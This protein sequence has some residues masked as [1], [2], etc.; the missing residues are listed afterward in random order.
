MRALRVA[1]RIYLVVTLCLTAGLLASGTLA[2]EARRERAA[3]QDV[4]HHDLEARRLATMTAVRFKRQV[5]EWKDILLR[6]YEPHALVK[7]TDAFERESRAVR[8]TIDT[9]RGTTADPAAL[10]LA[11]R[12]INAHRT[13]G[14]RYAA[15]LAVFRRADG[16]DPVTTDRMVQGQDRGATAVLDTLG[17]VLTARAAGRVSV[18]QS[19][20]AREQGEILAAVVVLLGLVAAVSASTVRSITRPL[21]VLTAAADALSRG[22]IRPM[23]D[24]GTAARRDELG[25]LARAVQGSG[26]YLRAAAGT[27]ERLACGELSMLAA[28]TSSEDV[29]AQAFVVL[30]NA[31]GG[32]TSEIS[33]VAEAA[34]EGRL[35]VR[36]DA[37]RFDGAFGNLVTQLNR[38]LEAS[39][40][41]VEDAQRV[42]DRLAA[43]DLTARMATT[44][45]GDHA[46]LARAL[47]AAL[48]T[49]AT[50]L[51]QTSAATGV[52]AAAGEHIAVG[53]QHLAQSAAEQAAS[54]EEVAASVEEL[55]V[56]A[57]QTAER[58]REARALTA[59]VRTASVDGVGEMTAL[60]AAVR[61][62][63]ETSAATARIV[64]TIDAIA[65][66]TNL[67]ALNA[68]VE[69]ARA[70]DA[71]RSFA[72]VADEVRS[73][74]QRAGAAA[75]ETAALIADGVCSA[76]AGAALAA[77]VAEQLTTIT[78]RA[79]EAAAVVDGIA[80]A[81][82]EQTIGVRQM[83]AALEQ[84]NAGTQQTAA[85]SE[86]AAAAAETLSAQAG[87][88][89]AL[90]RTFDLG[91]ERD[92]AEGSGGLHELSGATGVPSRAI[93]AF[94]TE[95]RRALYREN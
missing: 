88:L 29:L 22:D 78:S 34:A 6:G 55:A 91:T 8:A 60:R 63:Q 24:D 3:M 1:T 70:G 66:Q 51:R 40:A 83:S 87:D 47:N 85:T 31:L 43:R 57:A 53:S 38:S 15:A 54:L 21:V 48:D 16:R 42:L 14:D 69:A 32:V 61:R 59:D 49:L 36:G 82:A 80:A 50:T 65:F 81:S 86:I 84:L 5:Q 28:P 58:A 35:A 95:R 75:R 45:A 92:P 27:A 73:L 79:D 33:A 90:V 12:F 37:A 56:T 72:V 20:T 2:W 13:M 39:V 11:T 76:D 18:V 17:D 71:G 7:Y 41:P 89:R 10:A 94:R 46:R 4:M 68:A 52:V 9:L 19:D 25:I 44:Y 30:V 93:P 77:V 26:A 67:L 74:A 62:T 23:P 64:S